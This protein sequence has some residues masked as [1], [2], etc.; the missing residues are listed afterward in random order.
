[1][2][3]HLFGTQSAP[4]SPRP[5]KADTER[6]NRPDDFH[7]GFKPNWGNLL[8]FKRPRR[9]SADATRVG[10]V[11]D[12]PTGYW[13]TSYLTSRAAGARPFGSNA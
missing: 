8:T 1:M 10:G 5:E 13:W 9:W 2:S 12:R 3:C 4:H 11:H 6:L 7:P